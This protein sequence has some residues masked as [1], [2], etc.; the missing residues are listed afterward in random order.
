MNLKKLF[1][2][3]FI[4]TLIL[5]SIS[6]TA[7]ELLIEWAH[8]LKKKSTEV[9]KR[10]LAGV[11][12][13]EE[14]ILVA[15]S[16]GDLH[17]FSDSG[18]LKKSISFDGE[19]FLTPVV[20][21]DKN[22]LLSV[23]NSVFMLSP[24]LEY[25]WS[26]SGKTPVASTP[27][28]TSEHVIVQ[29]HDDSIHL[30]ERKAGAFKTSFTDDINSK[31][32]KRWLQSPYKAEDERGYEIEV[33]NSYVKLA[34]PLLRIS[35]KEEY[36]FGFSDG[37]IKSFSIKKEN[38]REEIVHNSTIETAKKRTQ[39]Y[40][41]YFYDILSTILIKDSMVFSNG[42]GGGSISKG[43]LTRFTAMKNLNLV[44]EKPGEIVGFGEGGVFLFDENGKVVSKPLNSPNFVSN[45]I[46]V[47]N[48]YF[49]STVGAG[50]IIDYRE[51]FIYLLSE[52]Y[53]KIH[54]IMIPNGVSAK[55]AVKED[56]VYIISDKGVVYKLKVSK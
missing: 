41:K 7:Q 11:V 42:E 37:S 30:F 48:Y 16:T 9:N 40:K 17:L 5:F 8:P 52:K 29:F 32:L 45:L 54:S 24:S 38:N 6:I 36:V 3:L 25:V 33:D 19:F 18:T 35:D 46:P 21:D 50:S 44:V 2:T 26:V 12:A 20:L 4:T 28:V 10:E 34:A 1:K 15:T 49:V 31:K 43:A 56:A 47:K 14:G 53:D 51:G 22:I 39:Y 27:Y 13:L 55:A 23:S